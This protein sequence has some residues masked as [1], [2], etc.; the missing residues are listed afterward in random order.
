MIKNQFLLILAG[1]PAAG[2]ST[3]AKFMKE[4][5]TSTA[6]DF[7]VK[8]VDPDSIRKEI[9]SQSFDHEVEF[10]VRA[11]NLKL[12]KDAISQENIVI[13][14]DLNYYTSMRHDIKEIAEEFSIPFFIIYIST[15][16][17]NCL[18]WNNE[19]GAPIPNEVI[20]RINEKFDAFDNYSW[21][22]PLAS[23]DISIVNLHN[24]ISSVISQIEMK[25]RDLDMNETLTQKMES[26]QGSKEKLEI[27]TRRIVG[28]YLNNPDFQSLKSRILYLRKI[29]IKEK[30]RDI[31]SEDEISRDFI[32][33]LKKGLNDDLA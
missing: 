4:A 20:Y 29:Y 21:D 19:R 2:K 33:F 22:K 15:P 23:F 13:S 9:S 3:F 17:E 11:N 8:I 25:L 28:E 18:Q 14:D 27:I 26:K 24:K 1:L 6:P 16:I 31:N 10:L 5:L 30:K 7:E 12:I 32:D